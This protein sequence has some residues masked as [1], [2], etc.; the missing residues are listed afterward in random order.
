M[1]YFNILIFIIPSNYA[2]TDLCSLFAS[3]FLDSSFDNSAGMVRPVQ[4]SLKD[5]IMG[6]EGALNGSM[7]LSDLPDFV[8]SS[9]KY[10]GPLSESII[11]RNFG[12]ISASED[13]AGLDMKPFP[14]MVLD[15]EPEGTF[16][17]V[18]CYVHP[19]NV[20]SILLTT[21]GNEIYICVL[22]GILV[23]KDRNLYIY[24]V[25][26]EEPGLGVPYFIGHS[27]ITLPASNDIFGREVSAR[28]L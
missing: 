22:C 4:I 10:D 16:D 14:D 25:P 13:Q 21:Q 15:T 12:D 1:Q 3:A 19:M 5:N 27:S 24:K 6:Q 2:L 8:P 11:C 17:L 9:R 18:G 7:P 23:N 28:H 20:T 26:L